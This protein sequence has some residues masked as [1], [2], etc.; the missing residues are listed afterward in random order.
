MALLSRC[1]YALCPG[2]RAADPG[3]LWRA[4]AAGAVPV[5]LGEAPL[6]PAAEWLLPDQPGL[7]GEVALGW[8]GREATGLLERLRA[9][10][11]LEWSARQLLGGRVLRAARERTCFGAP[12]PS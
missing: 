9:I 1:R 8:P 11:P 12:L 3:R 6:L 10:D 4:L 5:L 7:W 2:G